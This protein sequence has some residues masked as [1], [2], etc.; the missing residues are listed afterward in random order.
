MTLPYLVLSWVKVVHL[1][2]LFCCSG[3]VV[4]GGKKKM[5]VEDILQMIITLLDGWNEENGDKY[6][7]G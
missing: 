2:P 4:T 6:Q 3:C 7:P 5:T 1:P